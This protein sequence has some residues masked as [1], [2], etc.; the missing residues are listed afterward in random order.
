MDITFTLYLLFADLLEY[1]GRHLYPPA[2]QCARLLD[3]QCPAASES[4]SGFHSWVAHETM[5][6]V[7]ETYTSTFDLSGVCYPY[8]GYHLF[9]DN[10]KRSIFMAQLS[11]GYRER[12]F[13]CECELPDHLAVILRFLA[14]GDG[15]EFGQVLL[16]EGLFPA[17]GKMALAFDSHGVHP[18]GQ[19][20]RSLYL[21]LQSGPV[22]GRGDLALIEKGG[23]KND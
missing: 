3:E 15:D 23:L 13:S 14:G 12:G 2:Q 5:G 16:D 7:E 6:R 8:V 9:G 4:F 17:V 10:Y 11:R 22:A 18:Y 20:I 21:L 19:L 1:P